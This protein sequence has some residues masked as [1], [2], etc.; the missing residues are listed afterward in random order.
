MPTETARADHEAMLIVGTFVTAQQN[1]EIWQQFVT[2]LY[3]Q[4]ANEDAATRADR[5][6]AAA[7]ALAS[8]SNITQGR[9]GV[10][11]PGIAPADL[12]ATPTAKPGGGA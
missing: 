9:G 1:P 8:F 11:N 10:A 2:R 5:A 12:N 3:D 6:A 7:T 4:W